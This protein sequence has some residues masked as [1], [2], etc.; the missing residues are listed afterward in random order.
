MKKNT[1]FILLGTV[2]LILFSLILIYFFFVRK[3]NVNNNGNN[4]G[5]KE[6]SGEYQ[7]FTA[8]TRKPVSLIYNKDGGKYDTGYAVLTQIKDDK[9][10]IQWRNK[11]DDK[12]YNMKF[13]GFDNVMFLEIT[14]RELDFIPDLTVKFDTEN[15]IMKISL[16]TDFKTWYLNTE[17]RNGV[18]G[19]F[20]RPT[21]EYENIPYKRL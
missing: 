21:R 10:K 19:A 16:P 20:F 5:K 6:G 18:T 12:I 13:V 15:N 17:D 11:G 4:N 9:Y 1:K 2:I 3:H 8:K 14:D 7:I